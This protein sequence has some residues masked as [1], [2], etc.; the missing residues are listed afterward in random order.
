MCVCV[1]IFI[2]EHSKSFKV[3]ILVALVPREPNEDYS[4]NDTISFH[5][6]L[7]FF[8]FFYLGEVKILEEV[9]PWT[10][11]LLVKSPTL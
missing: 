9:E 3:V 1:L 10:E 2:F 5:F 7:L 6:S 8:I 11:L 4:Y